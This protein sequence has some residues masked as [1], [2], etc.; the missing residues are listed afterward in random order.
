MIRFDDVPIMEFMEP[1][2]TANERGMSNWLG[3][4]LTIRPQS[5]TGGII[6]A[7][8]GVLLNYGTQPMHTRV[9]KPIVGEVG[10]HTVH[11]QMWTK[12]TAR[13]TFVSC[14]AFGNQ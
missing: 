9:S 6:S 2:S 10:I 4:T 12:C 14:Q 5:R 11:L 3:D 8:R 7:T 1:K 13:D